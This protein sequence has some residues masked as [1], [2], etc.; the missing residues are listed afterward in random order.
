MDCPTCEAMVDAYV[1]GE[2]SAQESVAFERALESCPQCRKR[3]EETRA[4]SG[5][6]REIPREPAPDLLRARIERELRAIAGTAAPVARAP[7]TMRGLA[8]AASLIVAVSV[9]WIG[10]TFSGTLGTGRSG[11]D[12]AELVA[13]VK[14]RL[15]HY[16]APKRVLTIATVGRAANGKLDYKRLKAEA[17]E[18]LSN[19]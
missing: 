11:S 18:R 12:E 14:E 17:I 19:A 5:L 10:G 15:A 8:M 2:L 16:K 13:H 1:D 3:L 7:Q 4:M 9:G 6:L